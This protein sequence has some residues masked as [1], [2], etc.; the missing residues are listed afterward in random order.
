MSDIKIDWKKYVDKIYCIRYIGESEYR[1][2]KY[3]E[4]IKRVD[5]Y[6][7]ELYYEFVNINSPIYKDIYETLFS[8]FAKNRL[9]NYVI[10]C[11]FGHYYCMKHAE[12][13]GYERILILES[14]CVFLRDKNQ[15]IE[16]LEKSKEI[17]DN[18]QYSLC[19]LNGCDA[20]Y[21]PYTFILP[22]EFYMQFNN[23]Y[24]L[25]C[26]GF[27]IYSKNAYK[28]FTEKFEKYEFFINDSYDLIF[29]N[30]IN[31]YNNEVNICIQQDWVAFT[32]N[33]DV[34]YNIDF[35]KD[36]I[37]RFKDRKIEL[38]NSL[39]H[40][41]NNLQ[42]TSNYNLSYLIT[43]NNIYYDYYTQLFDLLNRSF[44]NKRLNINDYII[45]N[46]N[47]SD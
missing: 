38:L 19:V 16:I 28:L 42:K 10:D 8:E 22:T 11:A 31:V 6:D 27:N 4:E 25:Y 15:I 39:L 43:S 18:D 34:L 35:Q 40:N 17:M 7:S 23:E 37:D 12:H 32:V 44:F 45:N 2:Q 41:F 3:E 5:I 26:A 20:V 21:P 13:F 30:D 29:G 36:W 14:D 9:Y 24:S 1:K 33:F 46:D 47:T